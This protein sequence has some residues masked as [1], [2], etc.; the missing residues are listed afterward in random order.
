MM[1]RLKT[2]ALT[3]LALFIC[4]AVVSGQEARSGQWTIS[5]FW[6]S[7]TMEGESVLFVRERIG[8]P[9]RAPL[10]FTPT[11]IIGMK[12]A[13][14]RTVY[15]EGKDFIWKRG[16]REIE[17]PAGSRIP[18]KNRADMYPPKGAP[19][20][21]EG[22]RGTT[23]SLF[24]GEGHLFH[25]L[26]TEAT[27]THEE[28]WKGHRPSYAGDRLPQS[29]AKLK[30]RKPVTLLLL[31]DS[32]SEGY[33]A[34]GYTNSSPFMPPY[35]Q[36]VTLALESAYRTPVRFV[37]QSVAGKN[38]VWGI[39]Q[40]TK[41]AA[42][43]PDLMIV[44]FGMNDASSGMAPD[45]FAGNVRRIMD[46]VRAENPACEFILVAGMTGNP[47]WTHSAPELYPQYRDALGALAG[48]GIVL[49]DVTS[50]WT[51][52]LARKRFID[53]TGNGVNH[54]NDFGH[55]LYATVIS[56]VLIE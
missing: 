6:K 27:Y 17:L 33:N 41:A 53:M 40:A 56:G 55:R 23:S 25:E 28:R 35:G 30:A 19:Q 52:V 48:K 3:V 1:I 46:T 18:F 36:L 44:A 20:S 49:A 12:S 37:N 5:P 51:D 14:G 29:I 10:L 31:G 32:I 43:K 21:I 9:P 11:R 8:E 24:F 7:E 50:L 2:I 39:E 47:E 26:Q 13:D 45:V 54:P 42:E 34:S 38:T 22:R 4:T 16:S 15:E